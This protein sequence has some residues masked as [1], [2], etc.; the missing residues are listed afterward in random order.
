MSEPKYV[1][2]TSVLIHAWNRA[3]PLDVFP[4]FWR[5]FETHVEN[6]TLISSIEVKIELER[7]D[8]ELFAWIKQWSYMFIE[9]DNAVQDRVIELMAAYPKFVDERTNKSE[10]DPWVC[11]LAD[12][13]D[14]AVVTEEKGGTDLKPKIPYVCGKEN[15][16]CI[17][18]LDMIREL[19]I[20]I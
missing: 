18:L 7:K 12:T 16:R 6:G 9:I 15:I 1:L 11:A 20:K 3:Y 10:G 14:L 13:R 4:S 17:T 5:H 2:D 19:G 8:D